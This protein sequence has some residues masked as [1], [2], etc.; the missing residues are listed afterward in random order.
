MRSAFITH[1]TA[2]AHRLTT[3]VAPLARPRNQARPAQ[4]T[5][6]LSPAVR[7]GARGGSPFLAVW[8]LPVTAQC[9]GQGQAVRPHGA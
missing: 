3:T 9:D 5:T 6:E 8:R 2:P 1:P 7:V 4:R